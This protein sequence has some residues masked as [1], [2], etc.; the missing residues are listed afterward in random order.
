MGNSPDHVTSLVFKQASKGDSG[1]Y[2]LNSQMLQVYFEL[3]GKKNLGEI[4]AKTGLE[5]P[6]LKKVLSSL[7]K[8]KLIEKVDASTP[9]LDEAF[10]DYLF[11]QLSLAIGPLAKILIQD[12]LEDLRCKASEFP[13]ARAA[14]LI[15]MIGED[16]YEEA[17]KKSFR[18][19]MVLKLKEYR[20]K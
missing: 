16:I 15:E 14:E 8:V 6:T 4:A 2:P 3:D 5:I 13:V 11:V 12:A 9:L 20:S 7:L 1:K 10:F 19:K 17:D 18:Q